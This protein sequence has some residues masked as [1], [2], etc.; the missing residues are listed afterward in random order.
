MLIKST[1][2]LECQRDTDNNM[3]KEAR[4]IR[5]LC[6][7]GCKEQNWNSQRGPCSRRK[8]LPPPKNIQGK[9]LDR[10]PERL[11]ERGESVSVSHSLPPFDSLLE[12]SFNPPP[13]INPS[14]AL[15]PPVVLPAWKNPTL[16]QRCCRVRSEIPRH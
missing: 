5:A 9:A 8:E 12:N 13:N 7:N 11:G 16:L 14:S 15:R 3:G 1:S 2:L 4:N 6:S 10:Q